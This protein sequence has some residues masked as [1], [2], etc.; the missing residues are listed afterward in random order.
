MAPTRLLEERYAQKF[1]E[2]KDIVEVEYSTNY[3]DN[4]SLIAVAKEPTGVYFV[5]YSIELD[6][7]SVSEYE[8]KYSTTFK[9]NGTVKGE[10]EKII[11]QFENTIS[12]N[13][14][15]DQLKNVS[16]RPLSIRGMFPLIPGRYRISIL[17]K[18]EVSKE[19]T[20]LERDVVIPADS[21][22]LQMT[23]L[24][25]GY[26]LTSMPGERGLKPFKFGSQQVYFQSNRVF[27]I[28]ESLITAFQL[29]G[30]SPSQKENGELIFTFFNEGEEYRSFTRKIDQYLGLPNI[31]ETFSL[32]DFLPAH[33]RIRISLVVDG[34]EVFSDSDNFDITHS[35]VID[36][37]WIHTQQLPPPQD[38]V[39]AYQIGSQLFHSGRIREARPRLED[40][41]SKR[42]DFPPF[43][44]ALSRLYLRSGEYS[45][46]ESILGPLLG[47]EERPTYDSLFIMGQ[48]YQKLGKLD[49]AIDV[50]NRAVDSYGSN[51]YLLNHIGEC[52]FQLGKPKEALVVWTKSL[53]L[54]PNQPQVKK[55]VDA[56]KEKK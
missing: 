42:P 1:L 18:N 21:H 47:Q 6:R 26:K 49:R 2:Y 7:L 13:L 44:I 14:D 39:Y 30:L 31:T 3:I 10:E 52:Y 20:S 29:H 12:L 40:A 9:L 41:F 55:N 22:S 46:I 51:I 38:P 37:P 4:N 34:Q 27:T 36:R 17:L 11:D 28:S 8:G 24:T 53:E 23:S 25:L 45:K 5:H 32:A 43:A 56:L 15:Q 16:H 35:E 50:F 19:F 54:N 33:Y 48:A